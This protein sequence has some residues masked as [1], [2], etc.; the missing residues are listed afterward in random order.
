M[1]KIGLS[2]MDNDRSQSG[3]TL[4]EVLI[5]LIVLSVG[6]LGLAGLQTMSLRNN[7]DAYL[8]SQAIIQAY[9]LVDRMRANSGAASDYISS[10]GNIKTGTENAACDTITGCDG[11]QMALHDL[12]KWN[13]A[14]TTLLPQGIGIICRD[15]SDTGIDDGKNEAGATECTDKTTDPLVV[16]I[17]WVDGRAKDQPDVS[18]LSVL[19]GD[20]L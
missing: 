14:N 16:K 4:L 13:D 18:H 10:A 1:L 9:D 5:T 15:G 19:V 8:R 17:W 2:I 12:S 6:L 20:Q 3:F 7:H 11:G